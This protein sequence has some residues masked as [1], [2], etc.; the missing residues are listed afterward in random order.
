MTSAAFSVSRDPNQ[1][2]SVTKRGGSASSATSKAADE[3][4]RHVIEQR[5][6]RHRYGND[7]RPKPSLL[8]GVTAAIGDAVNDQVRRFGLPMWLVRVGV[9]AAVV[10][11]LGSAV[12]FRGGPATRHSVDG[13][14]VFEGRPLANATLAFHST[15]AQTTEPITLAADAAGVF[16][17]G[18]DITLPAGLYAVVVQPAAA[19]S[20]K[21]L[22]ISKAYADPAQTPL[23]VLVTEDLVGLK[24]LVRR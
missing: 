4:L 24:L 21:P 8:G 5:R 2:V 12:L 17:T 18:P 11:V 3:A 14:V 6:R 9:A 23:R 20:K 19:R 7:P 15:G 1:L 22:P 13:T 10:V 16:R